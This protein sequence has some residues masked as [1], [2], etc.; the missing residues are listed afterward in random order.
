MYFQI[1]GLSV[2]QELKLCLLFANEYPAPKPAPT[3]LMLKNGFLKKIPN[4]KPP[5]YPSPE[6]TN[7]SSTALFKII[8]YYSFSV[9]VLDIIFINS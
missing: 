4:P 7:K 6:K 8:S 5:I 2:F 3:D 1:N 9:K